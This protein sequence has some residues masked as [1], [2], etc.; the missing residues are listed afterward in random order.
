METPPATP[1]PTHDEPSRGL[2]R[3]YAVQEARGEGQEGAYHIGRCAEVAAHA[4]ERIHGELD[5]G[6]RFPV[7]RSQSLLDEVPRSNNASHKLSLARHRGQNDGAVVNRDPTD[8]GRKLPRRR[9]QTLS[10]AAQ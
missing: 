9:A 3:C 1:D 10:R 6:K 7:L 5:S 8:G 4:Y 2:E